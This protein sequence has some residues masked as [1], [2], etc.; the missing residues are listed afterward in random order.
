MPE[1][2]AAATRPSSREVREHFAQYMRKASRHDEAA[3]PALRYL[4]RIRGDSSPRGGR[5]PYRTQPEP[6]RVHDPANDCL[7]TGETVPAL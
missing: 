7:R 1:S 4:G 5:S 3:K 2:S 6:D